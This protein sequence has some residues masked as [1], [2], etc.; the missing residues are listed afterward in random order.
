MGAIDNLHDQQRRLLRF[1]WQFRGEKGFSPTY[2]E[3][4]DALGFS[5]K[6]HVDYHIQELE[7]LNCITRTPYKSRSIRLTDQGHETIGVRPRGNA[8]LVNLPV[9]GYIVAGEPVMTEQVLETVEITHDIVPDRGDLYGL[10]V[11]GDSMVGAHIS[12]GDIVIMRRDGTPPRNGDIVA[13][14]IRSSDEVTLKHFHRE[15]G[16]VRLVPANPDY[17]VIEAPATD[18]EVQGRVVAVIRQY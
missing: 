12:H 11:R 15:N 4:C 18:V 7:A 5:S 3:M 9:L 17:R 16:T 1:I 2:D 8:S 13:V 10:R 6:S 14:R